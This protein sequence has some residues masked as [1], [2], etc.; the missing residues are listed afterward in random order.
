MIKKRQG[1]QTLDISISKIRSPLATTRLNGREELVR[2]NLIPI[3]DVYC[4]VQFCKKLVAY[5]VVKKITI[6]DD[7]T[8][9]KLS[10]GALSYSTSTVIITFPNPLLCCKLEG[11]GPWAENSSKK[12]IISCGVL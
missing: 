1:S 5:A 11:D 6:H 9:R 2:L 10:F 12:S 8:K 7:I 3:K 4:I